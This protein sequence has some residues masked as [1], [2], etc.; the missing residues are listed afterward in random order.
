MSDYQGTTDPDHETAGFPLTCEDCHTTSTWL[1]ATFDHDNQYFP[2]YS[3]KHQGEWNDC[4][5]CHYNPSDYSS[6]SC[7][8]CHEHSDQSQVDNDH[9]EVNGYVYNGQSCYECHPDGD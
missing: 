6:F 4:S 1:G 9:S 8:L 7:I 5:D 3:G 2:I